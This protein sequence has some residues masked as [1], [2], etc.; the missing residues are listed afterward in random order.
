M[1]N[2]P[3]VT[4]NNGVEIPQLGFG[5]WQV[6]PEQVKDVVLTAF[7]TGYRSI[8]TAAAYRNE[9]GVG[10]AVAASGL[11]REEVF[12]T[13]KLANPE[14]G[15]DST[16]AAFEESIN[17]LGLDYVDLYLIHWPQPT[18]DRYV[19]TWQAFEKLQADGRVRAIGVSNFH[20]P[21]LDRLAAETNVTPVLN[22]IELH[23]NLPQN[24]LREY[25]AAHGI[26]TEAWSP[27]AA[28][29]NL[30]EDPTITA[31]AAAVGK[32]PAQ[33]ILRWH[34]QIGVIVI[35]RSTNTERIA[36]NFDIF[37]FELTA[38][39]MRAIGG[40]DNGGRTGGNPDE[41]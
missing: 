30:V 16:M 36:T 24:E 35:P 18:K 15:Y 38:D 32:T 12:I 40:L 34:L 33:V 23:P 14:Q 28:R 7:E 10:Q 17:Q 13:T 8:D 11:S 26:A 1:P 5:V 21:H 22:Q 25:H 37:D 41:G 31:I 4:L 3:T 20:A 6:P 2:V 39:H 29:N 19:E 9:K 27:L